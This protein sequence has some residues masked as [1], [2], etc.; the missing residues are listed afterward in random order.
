MT[1]VCDAGTK[2]W[3]LIPALWVGQYAPFVTV[4]S[5]VQHEMLAMSQYQIR[6]DKKAGLLI[7]PKDVTVL[8]STSG[9]VEKEV[10]H[11]ASAHAQLVVSTR[12]GSQEFVSKQDCDKLS[13]QLD[14]RFVR[15]E[16]LLS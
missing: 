15:F 5:T 9:L 4:F 3:V 10:H 12:T 8:G 16:A 1:N 14:E 2:D 7:S 11:E 13:S 6:T